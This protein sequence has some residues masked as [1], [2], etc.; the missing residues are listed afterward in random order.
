MEQGLPWLRGPISYLSSKAK[1]STGV[2]DRARSALQRSLPLRDSAGLRPASSLRSCDGRPRR[3]RF[4][5]EG[6]TCELRWL[7]MNARGSR[8]KKRPDGT[9]ERFAFRRSDW[10][11]IRASRLTQSS[12]KLRLK[13]AL[14]QLSERSK[15][16]TI[17]LLYFVRKPSHPNGWLG[18]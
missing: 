9:L 5:L 4:Y 18:S 15:N 16:D 7:M 1:K 11:R 2:V 12:W 14:F 3:L 17:V 6:A 8:V 13:H 10:L